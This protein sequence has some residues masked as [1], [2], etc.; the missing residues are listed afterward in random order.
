MPRR[1]V[2]SSKKHIKRA[3]LRKPDRQLHVQE[4]GLNPYDFILL[5]L[6]LLIGLYLLTLGLSGTGSTT[7]SP[8][9][10]AT[11]PPPAKWWDKDW[12]YRVP[13]KVKEDAGIDHTDYIVEFP[14]NTY[15]LIG[16]DKM[17]GTCRDIR[18]IGENNQPFAFEIDS[19]KGCDLSDTLIRLRANVSANFNGILAYIYYGNLQEETSASTSVPYWKTKSE[20][21]TARSALGAAAVDG[22]IYAIGGERGSGWQSQ[23][24]EIYDSATNTWSTGQALPNKKAY[25]GTAA[26]GNRIYVVGGLRENT[27][28]NEADSYVTT[29]DVWSSKASAPTRRRYLDATSANDKIY[30][31]GGMEATQ[32]LIDKTEEYDPGTNT[33]TAKAKI[34]TPRYDLAAIGIG[35]KIY[36]IGGR[37]STGKTNKNEMYDSQKNEWT[38]KSNMPTARYATAAAAV[39]DKIYVVG[40][41]GSSENSLSKLEIYDSVKD[42]WTTGPSMLSARGGLAT[43]AHNGKIYVIGGSRGSTYLKTNEEYTVPNWKLN[44]TALSEEGPDTNPPSWSNL[45]QST[46]AT[47]AGKLMRLSVIWSDVSAPLGVWFY[48]SYAGKNST[49]QPANSG[50][51]VQYEFD[52]TGIPDNTTVTW[53]SFAEDD[54]G[55]I[56]ESSELSF[57]VTGG[58]A[59]PAPANITNITE[60]KPVEPGADTTKP[61][62]SE[63]ILLPATID[64]GMEALIRVRATDDSELRSAV[65]NVDGEEVDSITLTGIRSTV[66]FSWKPAKAGEYELEVTVK[67]AAGN[68]QSV[69]K[70][71]KVGEVEEEKEPLDTTAFVALGSV[72]LV[73]AVVVIVYILKKKGILKFGKAKKGEEEEELTAEELGLEGPK[74]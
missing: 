71:V 58:P 8:T 9:A 31:I 67:D 34:P 55:N 53:K 39:D 24:L 16:A 21:P 20:M 68:S 66:D 26:V 7:F 54:A 14:L 37:T 45:S 3:R 15:N 46:N 60:V 12:Q 72:L 62:A 49:A 25:F 29:T 30:A 52:T 74:Y 35:S 43:A 42:E 65:L 4:T 57:T 2:R 27:I 17:D 13:V 56:G 50:Q 59:Q 10:A 38:T 41:V 1:I 40:G 44:V 22:K 32:V 11:S 18:V 48:D 47:T 33:W 70:T 64:P 19:A 6:L 28:L 51:K 36:A 5:G 63:I 61:T 23:I 73:I 69:K